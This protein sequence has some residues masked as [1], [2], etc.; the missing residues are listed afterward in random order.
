MS[1]KSL[2][3]KMPKHKMVMNPKSHRM[4]HPI[5]SMKELEKISVTHKPTNGIRDKMA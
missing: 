5:Y 3:D 2:L 4:A 1:K